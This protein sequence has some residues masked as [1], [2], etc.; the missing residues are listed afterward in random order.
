MSALR[1]KQF[2]LVE[3]DAEILVDGYEAVPQG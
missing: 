1:V 2:E 3:G